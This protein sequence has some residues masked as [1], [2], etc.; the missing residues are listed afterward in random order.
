MKQFLLWCERLARFF[1]PIDQSTGESD[2]ELTALK[3]KADAWI[4]SAGLQPPKTDR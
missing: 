2:G 1:R 3:R 4:N